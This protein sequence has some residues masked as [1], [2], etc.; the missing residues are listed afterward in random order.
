MFK[1]SLF[2]SSLKI[3]ENAPD[4]ILND[5]D[6]KQHQLSDYRGKKLVIYFFPKAFTPG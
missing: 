4:F 1:M 6:G 2:S 3:G 5:Q